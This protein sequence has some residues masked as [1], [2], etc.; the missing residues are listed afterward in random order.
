MQ[1]KVQNERSL[2]RD[3]NT[4]AILETD[5][6]KLKRHR[7][8]IK[9]MKTKSNQIELLLNKIDD[10]EKKLERITNGDTNS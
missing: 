7:A 8:L 1:V 3:S 10:L 2:V 4:G 5:N 6:I 9:S